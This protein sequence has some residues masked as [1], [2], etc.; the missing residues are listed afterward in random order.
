M[1]NCFV[2]SHQCASLNFWSPAAPGF[3]QASW[4]WILF[5]FLPPSTVFIFARSHTC[6]FF[7]LSNFALVTL[8]AECLSLWLC[9]WNQI[10]KNA[11]HSGFFLVSAFYS[12][13]KGTKKVCL[14]KK[15]QQPKITW[16][17][18]TRQEKKTIQE[19]GEGD[20]TDE[21]YLKTKA[22]E[23][24]LKQDTRQRCESHWGNQAKGNEAKTRCLK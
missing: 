10:H 2:F 12:C 21:I 13:Q 19:Q 15:K 7:F 24:S 14:K 3:E 16:L 23:W 11:S 1:F 17:G 5:C 18:K 9:F 20:K 22:G 6:R 8:A 4:D